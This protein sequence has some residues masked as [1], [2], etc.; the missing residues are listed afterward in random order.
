MRNI[1]V[2]VIVVLVL[3]TSSESFAQFNK[4]NHGVGVS[5]GPI[6][7]IQY[8]IPISEQS[9]ISIDLGMILYSEDFDIRNLGLT[10]KYFLNKNDLSTYIGLSGASLSVND[11]LIHINVPV[12]LQKYVSK[13]LAIFGGFNPGIIINGDV[14]LI[15]G[16]E[17]GAMLYF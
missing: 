16:A 12:G 2:L 3:A 13:D 17:L 14:T 1:L 10:F 6:D 8:S 9:Q 15:I 7:K 4:D 11:V 5:I